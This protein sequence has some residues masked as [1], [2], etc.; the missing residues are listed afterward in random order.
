MARDTQY[1]LL[2]QSIGGDVFAS[3]LNSYPDCVRL[4]DLNGCVEFMNPRGIAL[5]EI[6]NFQRNRGRY[7][8][9][10][11]PE[12]SRAAVVSAL[13]AAIAGEVRAF[14]AFCPTAKGAPRWWDT[15]IFPMFAP[16]HEGPFKLLARSRDITKERETRALLHAVVENIPAVLIAKELQTGRFVLV[17]RAAEEASGLNRGTMIGK[18]D[19]DLFPPEQAELFRSGDLETAASGEVRIFEQAIPDSSGDLRHYRTKKIALADEAGARH[20]VLIA[21]DV[22]DAKLSADKLREALEQANAASEAKSAFLA[23]MSHEIRTPLNGVLGMVQAL[24]AGDATPIQREQ[25]GIIRRSGEALLSILNDILDLS[26]IEAGRL[27]TE[28]AEFDL[29]QVLLGACA[30]FTSQ[31]EEKGLGFEI[32]IAD[33]ARG[34]YL[35]DPARIRRLISN[36]VSNALKFTEVGRVVL[37]AQ[38]S[39]DELTLAVVDTGIGIAPSQAQAIFEPFTQGDASHTR[40][41]S[42]SGLGLAICRGL[43]DSMQGKIQVA[44]APGEGSTFTVV[45]PLAKVP[46]VQ[47]D[48]TPE[49]PEAIETQPD[50]RILAAEDNQT[51]QLVLRTLLEQAG[52]T[53]VIVED[54]AA[55]VKAWEREHWDIILMDIQMPVMD[56]V[57]ATRAIRAREAESRRPRTPILAVTANA[58]THQTPEYYAAGIDDVVPKPVEALLLFS[59]LERAL[60]GEPRAA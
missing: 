56:G 10:L 26:R 51:N 16:G 45:L 42:G 37:R 7:W 35:G 6:E 59:A 12:E 32:S 38:W 34:A 53:P 33:E 48:P 49:T 24:Q 8:P 17:N 13:K 36:L 15:V 52:L 54:G 28:L 22:T 29:E 14:Q 40:R 2:P 55:A 20:V 39:A 58:M 27:E 30:T 1:E 46:H 18:T 19:Y 21:D 43:V 50:I 9:D 4:L 31:A 57:S 25:L 11:W 47:L 60:D 23:T 3:A 41:F 5:F 44:S